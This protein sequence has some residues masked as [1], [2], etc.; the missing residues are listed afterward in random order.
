[1]KMSPKRRIEDPILNDEDRI[2][3]HHHFSDLPPLKDSFSVARSERDLFIRLCSV[4][5]KKLVFSYPQTDETK[6]NVPAFYLTELEK[7]LTEKLYKYDYSF[8]HIKYI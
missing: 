3:L 7:I 1:M 4:A 6:D 5:E 8:K 2:F